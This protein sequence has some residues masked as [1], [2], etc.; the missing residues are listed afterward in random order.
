MKD[1]QATTKSQIKIKYMVQTKGRPPTFILFVNKKNVRQNYENQIRRHFQESFRMYGME[2]RLSFRTA[3]NPFVDEK[4]K[5]SGFGLG[6]HQARKQRS[7]NSLRERYRGVT[8]KEEG[9]MRI[10]DKRH[11]KKRRRS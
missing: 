3:T 6:G 7:L 4:P 1:V 2:V 5:R 10:A 8:T 9:R 11:R